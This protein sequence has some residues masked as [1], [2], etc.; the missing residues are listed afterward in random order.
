MTPRQLTN[1]H[2]TL[3]DK[4][5]NVDRTP[6]NGL[7]LLAIFGGKRNTRRPRLRW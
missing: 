4:V 7:G 6:Q 1:V 5:N 3:L 2:R